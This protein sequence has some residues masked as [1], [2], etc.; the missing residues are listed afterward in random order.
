MNASIKTRSRPVFYP[1]LTLQ[2][3]VEFAGEVLF[4]RK[5]EG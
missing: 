2:I 3:F 1:S 4:Y 5:Y